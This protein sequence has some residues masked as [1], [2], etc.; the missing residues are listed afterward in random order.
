MVV[1]SAPSYAHGVI[2]PVA[3]VAALAEQ[4]GVLC[5]VDA[6]I[7]GMLLPY[8]RRLG[9]PLPPVGMDVPG[10][11]SLSVDLHKY[12]YATKGTSVLLFRDA[13]A[14]PA[15]LLR[16]R[17]VAGLPG[18]ELDAPVDQVGGTAGGCLGGAPL[19]R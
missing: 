12:A 6:C 10:V 13:A 5:H 9:V 18:G 1:V 7:G 16:V 8:L 17:R 11:T 14:A 15:L 3:E 2:D 4:H 19:G